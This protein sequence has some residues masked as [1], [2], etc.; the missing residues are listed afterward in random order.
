MAE[1]K[2]FDEL[3]SFQ[4]LRNEEKV[5]L[6]EVMAGESGAE[7]VRKYSLPMAEGLQ[8]NYAAKAVDDQILSDLSAL[9]QEAELSSKFKE[10][11]EG[12]VINTGEKRLVL[13]HLTRGQLGSDVIADGVNKREFYR[14]Q[15]KRI[16]D[17]AQDVHEGKIVNEHGEKFTAVV[18]I[19]I[20]GSDLGPRA[21]YLALQN[22]AKANGKDLMD[23]AFIS[24]VDPDDAASVLASV[25]VAHAIFILVSKS[26]TT[27]E[28]LTN[29]TFV[30]NALRAQGLDPAR[31]MI[32]V[33]SETSPLAHNDDYMAAFYMDDYIGGRYSSTSAVGGAVLSLAFGPEVF[34]EFLEGA[35]AEDQLAKETDPMKNPDMLDALIGVYERNFLGYES[36]AVLPYSQALSRFPAHLQQLD[37]ESNGKS[38]NRFGEPVS[39]PTGPVLFGEPGT[40]G[41]HSFYQ[42][43]HQ[44]KNIVPLQFVGFRKSQLGEDDTIQGSTSQQKLCANVAAQIVAFACGKP[45]ENQNKNF[46]GG[47][48]SSIIIGD[49]VTPRSLGALLAH[50]ENKVM[51]QGFV[52]N[53]N[54][55]DQEGVQL[56]KVLAKRVL[57][58]DTEGALAEYSR[59]LD[60]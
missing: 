8:Y 16:A 41:Q 25:D 6:P 10:L 39:Y 42:L 43:L 15:Q 47:R 51:F 26:G 18:Q 23:A 20:G 44:G 57:A 54:S 13:H 2:N 53:L 58:H 28:T 11:Y 17:F 12:A 34:A 22:W 59:L 46:E 37:M 9:A 24:N 31:H 50:F 19:G 52:W 3:K 49:E 14:E 36:T 48:P 45:D 7:R 56:G 35:A 5:D 30:Q 27:L 38:V 21:M 32:A 4:T 33:T 60:I 40:N 55:F 1:W 29:E